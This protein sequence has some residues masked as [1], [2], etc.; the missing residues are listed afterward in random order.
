[1]SNPYTHPAAKDA[2]PQQP[3]ENTQETLADAATSVDKIRD[4][5]FGSQIR[6]Y[7]A[8][9]AHLEA[10]LSQQTAELKSAM[11]HQLEWIQSVIQGESARIGRQL[12]EEREERLSQV[13]Q[14][15]RSLAEA[16]TALAGR[17]SEAE[18]A[19][20]D[21]DATL[22]NDLLSQSRQLLDQMTQQHESLR[23]LLATSLSELRAEKAD[24]SR[25][26]EL[27]REIASRLGDDHVARPE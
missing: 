2:Q 13:S 15:E 7:D 11:D 5:I 10:S 23:A 3:S 6:N 25:M 18:A 12:A 20:R 24:R 17:L 9:F 4:I 8:R 14:L 1:M 21:G 27:F 19:M 16:Q 22:R 26:S